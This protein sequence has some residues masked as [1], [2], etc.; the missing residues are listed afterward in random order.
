[1]TS[2]GPAPEAPLAL[3]LSGGGA[4]GAF[5]VGVYDVLQ[6]DPRGLG[7]LPGVVSGTSAGALNGALLAAGLDAQQLLEFWVDLARTPPVRA[8]REFFRSL[9][10][11]LLRLA[12]LEPVRSLG[13]RW[14]ELRLLTRLLGRHPL[15]GQSG[16]SALVLEFVL[17]ARFDSVSE[18]L[19]R[20]ATTYLF[21]TD[22]VGARIRKALRR[23]YLEDTPV[24]VAINVI[25]L[26]TG[27]VT[28]IVNRA[29]AK[30]SAAAAKH[31]LVVDRITPEM[32]LASA[33]IP[34]LF[35]PVRV[36]EYQFWD[37]G[38]LVNTPLAPAVALGGRRLVPVLVTPRHRTPPAERLGAHLERL[39]DTFLL[40]AY[41]VDRKLLLTRNAVAAERPGSGLAQVEL[42]EPIRPAATQL[43]NAGS[44]LFFEPAV[45]ERMFEAGRAAARD[46]LD[47]GPLRDDAPDTD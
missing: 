2:L 39:A 10:E 38:L 15:L 35:N 13:H 27:A 11:E 36:G 32:I 3:V 28:R 26:R 46:W 14:R 33:S 24:A 6:R 25:D 5:Q 20:I 17:T 4:R 44:Y 9:R 47:R 34:L 31:Y 1:M 43:F 21:N 18:V 40:N 12:A 23:D 19:D 29:P 30:R 37:G 42:F 41:N 7:G 16:L 45:L 8:N 22:E